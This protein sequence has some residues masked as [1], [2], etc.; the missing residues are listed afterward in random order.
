MRLED[1]NV[2]DP[3]SKYYKHLKGYGTSVYFIRQINDLGLIQLA[4][5]VHPSSHFSYS[6]P[7]QL[8][9][10]S[11]TKAKASTLEMYRQEAIL[12]ASLKPKG[13]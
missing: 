10:A 7:Y 4:Q 5:E 2:G 12:S 9:P 11:F 1:C 3:V 6:M 13:N 8:R